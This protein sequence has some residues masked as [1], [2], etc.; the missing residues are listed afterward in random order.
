MSSQFKKKDAV[1]INRILMENKHKLS[2]LKQLLFIDANKIIWCL[3]Q[4]SNAVKQCKSEVKK[5]KT[6][7][8]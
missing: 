3:K 7:N 8:V 5:L 4:K 1:C 6:E 2:T